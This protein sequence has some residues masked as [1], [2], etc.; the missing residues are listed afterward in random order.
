MEIKEL[1]ESTTLIKQASVVVSRMHKVP[2]GR[3]I[4]KT[5]FETS[6]KP[7]FIRTR[8]ETGAP[9]GR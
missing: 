9:K 8:L 3:S 2:A 6:I 7:T 1:L 4:Y 5:V